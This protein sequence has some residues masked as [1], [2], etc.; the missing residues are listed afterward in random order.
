MKKK[1]YTLAL[2]ALMAAGTKAAPLNVCDFE[3]YEIGT[4]WTLWQMEG[5]TISSVARV[6]ADPK[7][8]NNK[9]LHITLKDWGCHPEFVIPSDLRGVALTEHYSM[10]RYKLYR[11]ASDT[12]NWKQFAAFVGEEEL[13]RDEGYPEQG[14]TGVWQTKG[15]TPCIA[16]TNSSLLTS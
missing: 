7:N 12:D 6:E 4:T 15:N 8:K 2:A 13:Y 11:S 3:S 16:L 1:I 10:V 9:V 5:N 14:S